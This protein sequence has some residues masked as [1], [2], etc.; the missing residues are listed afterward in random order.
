MKSPLGIMDLLSTKA[1]AS[2][3]SHGLVL[4]AAEIWIHVAKTFE[5]LRRF[6]Y[7]RL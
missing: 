4:Q 1:A 5:D 3:E 6:A 2:S 7:R